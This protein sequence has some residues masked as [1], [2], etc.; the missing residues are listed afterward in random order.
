M[1]NFICHRPPYI[2]GSHEPEIPIPPPRFTVRPLPAALARLL[3]FPCPLDAQAGAG[4]TAGAML[5]CVP[6]S[7]QVAGSAPLMPV[8]APP[9]AAVALCRTGKGRRLAGSYP[10]REYTRPA[11]AAQ[12]HFPHAVPVAQ[13]GDAPA[14]RARS[15]PC[16]LSSAQRAG[17]VPKPGRSVVR[18]PGKPISPAGR[19]LLAL[20]V[21]CQAPGKPCPAASAGQPIV[22]PGLHP[23]KPPY[24][25]F[26]HPFLHKPRRR[27]IL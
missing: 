23:R 9:H 12:G 24:G 14:S 16:R 15:F 11:R 18:S 7:A 6:C 3:S 4:S 19:R 8:S 17:S 10:S 25:A 20:P 2:V 1:T 26:S 22:R 27:G 5:R 13:R 21:R